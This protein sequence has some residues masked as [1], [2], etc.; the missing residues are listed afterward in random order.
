[1][2]QSKLQL[3]D[4]AP[5]TTAQQRL[6]QMQHGTVT[7]GVKFHDSGVPYALLLLPVVSGRGV[8]CGKQATILLH[9]LHQKLL[10][11]VHAWL[12]GTTTTPDTFS[13]MSPAGH[14]PAVI[15][16]PCVVG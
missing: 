3:T 11:N 15:T 4:L 9:N 7:A 10:K 13:S 5:C 14:C 12:L 1:M 8:V 2:H 16:P 6:P